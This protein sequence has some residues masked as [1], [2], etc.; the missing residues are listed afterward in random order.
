MGENAKELDC[1]GFKLWYTGKVRSRNRV[2]IIVD[3]EWTE[4]I[5]DV[6]RIGDQIIPLKFVVKQETINVISVYEPHVG[7]E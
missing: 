4:N 6:K 1:S 7:L 3:R 5:V 2:G